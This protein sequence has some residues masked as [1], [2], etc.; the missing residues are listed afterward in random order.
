MKVRSDFVT[1]SSSS[2][3]IIA[4][5]KD[6]TENEIRTMLYGLKDNIKYLIECWEGDFD[7]NHCDVIRDAY[8]SGEIDTAIKF[9][10]EDLTEYLNRTSKYD[11]TIDDWNLRCMEACSEDSI[12]KDCALYTFGYL[13]ESE[14]L[15]VGGSD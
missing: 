14:H 4:R 11:M 2:S 6:C 10:I 12:L 1:N 9:A 13:M 5:H 3:F 15:K 8:E 7:C